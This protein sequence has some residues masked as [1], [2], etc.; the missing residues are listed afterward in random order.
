MNP[1]ELVWNRRLQGMTALYSMFWLLASN[2]VGLW[3]ASLLI[4]P[5]LGKFAGEFTY[6]RWMPIHMDWQLYGWCSLPLVG[7]LMRYFLSDI[8]K[9][10]AHLGFLVWSIALGLGGILSL[11]GIVSGKLFLNWSSIGRIAFPV[12]QTVLWAILANG[13]YA[14]WQRIGRMDLKFFFQLGMLIL[15]LVSPL[16]LFWTA[17]NDVYPPIDPESG[18]ATGHSLLASSL[19]VIGIF[20]VFPLLLKLKPRSVARSRQIV[21]AVAFVISLSIWLLLDHG[22]ASNTQTGQVLGLGILVFWAPLVALYYHAYHWP[23]GL[24]KWLHAFFFWLA[25][26]TLNGFINFL[27]GILD[28]MKFTNGLVAHAHLAMAG[29]VSAFNILILGTIGHTEDDDPWCDTLAFWL[30]Q[31]GVFLY[32][33]AMTIQG[34]REGLDPTVLFEGNSVTTFFYSLRLVAGGIIIAANLR[35]LGLLDRLRRGAMAS[36]QLG[37]GIVYE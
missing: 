6:G 9:V 27:P 28:V 35:W 26:L 25:F 37:R 24:R 11:N 23:A 22:N 1:S 18:G 13:W 4:W 32:V 19:G 17:G 31:S 30:W 15:L 3:L 10:D 14:R 5:G 33:I 20:G 29:M 7:L 12:A 16:A 8:F 34:V 21:Y 2:I 36:T